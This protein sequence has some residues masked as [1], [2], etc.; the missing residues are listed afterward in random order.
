MTNLTHDDFIQ[1]DDD[2]PM[3]IKCNCIDRQCPCQHDDGLRTS[4][5]EE[6]AIYQSFGR[7][8]Q[9]LDKLADRIAH[10]N[11]AGIH[12]TMSKNHFS[13]E[14]EVKDYLFWSKETYTDEEISYMADVIGDTAGDW[15]S[16]LDEVRDEVM[17]KA[18]DGMT[19]SQVKKTI[20]L[21]NK[22]Y[23]K[24]ASC[25]ATEI[26]KLEVE[27]LGWGTVS[28][29]VEMGRENDEG[30][31]ASIFARDHRHIFIGKKGGCKIT[32]TKTKTGKWRKGYLHGVHNAVFA[33][34]H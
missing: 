5:K 13:L 7:T 2:G 32:G 29:I 20:L 9:D 33:V 31:M 3:Y 19:P 10:H 34:T 1:F 23:Y 6:T 28:L 14:G 25:G 30:T 11:I 4:T 27:L 17:E 18:K 16:H 8:T 26:K 24:N 15:L 21:I 22:I 12:Q